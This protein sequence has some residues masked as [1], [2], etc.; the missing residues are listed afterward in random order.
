MK[1]ASVIT[2]VLSKVEL[3]NAD[4][5]DS[6]N[7][8]L[9]KEKYKSFGENSFSPDFEIIQTISAP[10][11]VKGNMQICFCNDRFE[12]IEKLEVPVYS[13]FLA[14]CIKGKDCIYKIAVSMSLS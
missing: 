6:I 5:E 1:H 12:K 8:N 4:L 10:I 7:H 14:T 11:P 13:L 3:A 9:R 2:S